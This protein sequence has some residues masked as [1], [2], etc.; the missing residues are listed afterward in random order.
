MLPNTLSQF[1][2][3]VI[4]QM[5]V[6]F[7]SHLTVALMAAALDHLSDCHKVYVASHSHMFVYLSYI[8]ILLFLIILLKMNYLEE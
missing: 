7:N 1:P 4:Q 5:K 3:A 6:N 2:C 8:N